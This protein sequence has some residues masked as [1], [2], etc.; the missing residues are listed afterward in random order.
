M[1]SAEYIKNKKFVFDFITTTIDERKN[2][3]EI[4]HLQ[5]LQQ[6]DAGNVPPNTAAENV[7]SSDKL[8]KVVQTLAIPV[9]K[10]NEP[11][12]LFFDFVEKALM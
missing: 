9:P 3:E 8:L 4:N 6:N 7:V 1:K 12:N 5:L 10:K 2:A 11:W